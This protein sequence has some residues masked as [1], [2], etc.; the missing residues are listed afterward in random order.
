MNFTGNSNRLLLIHRNMEHVTID[1]PVD[2]ML[3]PQFYT[4]KKEPLPVKFAYQ[5]K[6]IAPSLFD[7]LLDTKGTYDYFVYREDDT[8]VFIAYDM[9]E[10]MHFLEQKGIPSEKIGKI[11]FA[12]QARE[13]ITAPIPLGDKEALAVL[14][15][16]VVVVPRMALPGVDFLTF[17]DSFRPSHGVRPES[18][19]QSLFTRKQAI[20]VTVILVL[21][22][23][24]WFAEGMRY[25]KT[26]VKLQERL[27]EL[28]EEHPALQSAYARESI[29]TKY[30]TIDTAERK[31]RK[32]IGK[33]AGL[34]FKGVTLTEFDMTP[35][36]FKAVF[37]LSDRKV[38]KRF[39]QLL[40]S[41][42]FSKNSASSDKQIIVEGRL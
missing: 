12:Q 8:W 41:A 34:I 39:N 2:I 17:D 1:A 31:K 33:I 16:M 5:A 23:T 14:D 29:A 9:N 7:G 38:A 40:K 30:R 32:I 25:G 18:V 27:N 11:Y 26:N 35:Q 28:Y 20:T 3:T 24:I 19:S 15:D 4:V 21:F 37:V 13:K 36:K 42:G 10:V 6:K 22:G